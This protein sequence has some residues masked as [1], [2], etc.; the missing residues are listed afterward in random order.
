MRKDRP[1]RAAEGI[2]AWRIRG[3]CRAH[4][5]DTPQSLREARRACRRKGPVTCRNHRLKQS[6]ASRETSSI[7]KCQ[8][9]TLRRLR[10]P[11]VRR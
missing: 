4:A 2:A 10:A 1:S 8:R 3:G 7:M 5:C 9:P 11:L 6:N